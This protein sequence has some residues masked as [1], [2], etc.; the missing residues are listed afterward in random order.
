MAPPNRGEALAGE[1][2][3]A[4]VLD[5]VAILIAIL[6]AHFNCQTICIPPTERPANRPLLRPLLQQIPG[7]NLPNPGPL[8]P[9]IPTRDSP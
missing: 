1:V 6:I 9:A 2:G 5:D 8:H 4:G 3:A 7:P